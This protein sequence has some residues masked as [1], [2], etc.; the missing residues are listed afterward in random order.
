M[1]K[2]KLVKKKLDDVKI[3]KSKI[4][5]DHR[6][7]F[8]KVFSKELFPFLKTQNLFIKEVNYCITNK[9]GTIRGMHFQSGLFKEDK[10]V[11]CLNGEI[12]DVV[13]D[14]RK[15]SKSFLS[16]KSF[17]LNEKK[18]HSLFIPKGF[19][20][21]YQSVTDNTAVLYF[22]SKEYAPKYSN[23]I[24]PLSN[25]LK[26]KWPIRKKIISIKDKNLPHLKSEFKGL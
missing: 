13:V 5:N 11:T 2:N 26:I 19:A 24:N 12:F 7:K 21:G 16:C 14:L 8:N 22:M 23:G 9:K 15:N 10:I 25:L 1:K 3:I 18:N 6:G 4:F 20:H 17:T